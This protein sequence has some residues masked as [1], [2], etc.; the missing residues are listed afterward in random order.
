MPSCGLSH[1]VVT[2][3]PSC[4]FSHF[5]LWYSHFPPLSARCPRHQHTERS[6]PVVQ[7]GMCRGRA[8]VPSLSSDRGC[9]SLSLLRSL[10]SITFAVD[11]SQRYSLS[12]PSAEYFFTYMFRPDPLTDKLASVLI[13]I[14]T[15][16]ARDALASTR[17]LRVC[18]AGGAALV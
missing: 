9:A 14:H 2:M 6:L 17:D 4:G 18:S 13:Y 11:N 16:G 5:L 7:V 10:F 12:R 1:L 8:T 15:Y 3:M